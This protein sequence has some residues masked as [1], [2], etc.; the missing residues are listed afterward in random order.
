LITRTS[1]LKYYSYQDHIR[2][3]NDVA[4]T[5]NDTVVNE[6]DKIVNL[7]KIIK[8]TQ[9]K[10]TAGSI[11]DQEKTALY[12]DIVDI[13]EAKS[14]YSNKLE[15]MRTANSIIKYAL[16]KIKSNTKDIY[17]QISSEV[18]PIKTAIVKEKSEGKVNLARYIHLEKLIIDL[19]QSEP[20]EDKSTFEGY[21][22]TIDKNINEFER[23]E[24][25]TAVA[26]EPDVAKIFEETVKLPENIDENNVQFGLMVTEINDIRT[27]ALE[28]LQ[29]YKVVEKMNN[30][31]AK[32]AKS[33]IHKNILEFKESFIKANQI[34]KD[35]AEKEEDSRNTP[36]AIAN[37]KE[38]QLSL[39]YEYTEASESHK[40]AQAAQAAQEIPQIPE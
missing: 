17:D 35:E 16:N 21:I 5:T 32:K 28:V 10:V 31:K 30:D 23:L 29:F 18:E 19:T 1:E 12:K 27:K 36:K 11:T 20:T 38:I 26:E 15:L 13:C 37:I 39:R 6:K 40:A 14:E 22:K 4:I 7:L 9:Q 2:Y 8:E 24:E 33:D 34:L 3:A 25:E